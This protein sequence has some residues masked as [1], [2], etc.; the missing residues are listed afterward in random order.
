MKDRGTTTSRTREQHRNAHALARQIINHPRLKGKLY[1]KH[2]A[3]TAVEIEVVTVKDQTPKEVLYTKT[4]W[5]CQ[6][7]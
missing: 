4:S 5:Q 1:G 3:R 7:L 6:T 2:F